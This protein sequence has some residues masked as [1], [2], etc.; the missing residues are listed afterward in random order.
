MHLFLRIDVKNSQFFTIKLSRS[1][2][3]VSLD[4]N[5]TSAKDIY[6]LST[7]NLREYFIRRVNLPDK[8]VSD[9]SLE[10]FRPMT[11]KEYI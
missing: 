9:S 3:K 10:P 2:G 5:L 4:F 7:L 11:E 1:R 6:L 8:L